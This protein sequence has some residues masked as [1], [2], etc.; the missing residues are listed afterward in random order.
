LRNKL[1]STKYTHIS[2]AFPTYVHF[3][4]KSI[5]LHLIHKFIY[6]LQMSNKELKS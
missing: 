4:E 6:I 5:L 1:L 2:I 3:E